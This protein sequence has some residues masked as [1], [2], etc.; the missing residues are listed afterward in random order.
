[1]VSTS[2]Q[3]AHAYLVPVADTSANRNNRNLVPDHVLASDISDATDQPPLE[4]LTQFD[5]RL[6]SHEL[7]VGGESHI[8]PS[9]SQPKNSTVVGPE[10][11]VGPES[12]KIGRNLDIRGVER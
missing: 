10:F 9:N 1:M 2:L 6:V 7:N 3:G 12:T 11:S 5:G 4:E 8:G